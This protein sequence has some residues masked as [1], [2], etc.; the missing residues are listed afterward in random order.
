MAIVTYVPLIEAKAVPLDSMKEVDMDG[1]I[2]VVAHADDGFFAFEKMCPHSA[3]P[4]TLGCLVDRT[5]ECP[6]HHYRFDMETGAL[7]EPD[8]PCEALTTYKVEEQDGM[9]CL[10]IEF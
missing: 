2:V 3:T 9:V 6:N 10:K 1:R 8:V 5:V 7:V 4:L